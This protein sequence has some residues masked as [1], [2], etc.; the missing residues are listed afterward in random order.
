MNGK[1]I[2]EV[3]GNVSKAV[4]F[5]KGYEAY[6]FCDRWLSCDRIRESPIPITS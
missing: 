3:C 6:R 1:R 5:R 4:R 2:A